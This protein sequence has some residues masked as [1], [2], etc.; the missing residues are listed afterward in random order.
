MGNGFITPSLPFCTELFNTDR[1]HICVFVC[2]FKACI[3]LFCRF[4]RVMNG[5]RP[6]WLFHAYSIELREINHAKSNTDANNWKTNT[7]K[8]TNQF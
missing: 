3:D 7:S 4:P 5:Y 2:D 8:F 1:V 6:R